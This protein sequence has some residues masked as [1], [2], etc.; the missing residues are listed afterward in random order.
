[1]RSSMYRRSNCLE[2]KLVP[3]GALMYGN[4]K[5]WILNLLY[6]RHWYTRT[7]ISVSPRPGREHHSLSSCVLKNYQFSDTRFKAK[8][9]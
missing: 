7:R 9:F 5:A 4:K 6:Q 2:V 1:M 3:W 8:C